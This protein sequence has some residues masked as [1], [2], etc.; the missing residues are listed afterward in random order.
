MSDLQAHSATA[1]S[2]AQ[3]YGDDCLNQRSL[4]LF[5]KILHRIQNYEL[6]TT[7]P[8]FAFAHYG[9]EQA[10]GRD[11]YELHCCPEM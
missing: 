1:A 11:S 7:I 6:Q 5:Q 4:H 8:F 9:T 10:F 3:V 2:V